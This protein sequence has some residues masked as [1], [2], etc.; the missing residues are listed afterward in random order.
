MGQFALFKLIAEAK[1]V[2]AEERVQ[3]FVY[4]VPVGQ[5]ELAVAAIQAAVEKSKVITV[6]APVCFAQETHLVAS[7]VKGDIRD[8]TD[9]YGSKSSMEQY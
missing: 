3:T 1:G 8:R 9:G 2:V 5:P 4:S 7:P 6:V